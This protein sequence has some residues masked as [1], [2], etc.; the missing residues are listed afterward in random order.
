[1]A[2]VTEAASPQEWM[3]EQF[4]SGSVPQRALIAATVL[5][6]AMG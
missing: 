5:P 1:M 6:V 3:T 2:E 4:H